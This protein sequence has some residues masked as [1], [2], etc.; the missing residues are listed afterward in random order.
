MGT[1]R[2]DLP[3][4]LSENHDPSSRVVCRETDIA[5]GFRRDRSVTSFSG[6]W[7]TAIDAETLA[8]WTT[9]RSRAQRAV[10]GVLVENSQGPRKSHRPA[11]L[12]ESGT[13]G[14]LTN[15]FLC[16]CCSF[17]WITVTTVSEAEKEFL[18]CR[19]FCVFSP[20]VYVFI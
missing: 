8:N 4:H 3:R 1:F 10:Y 6:N 2:S 13:G 18:N 14:I 11:T 17:L 7:G 5:V 12:T 16:V 15:H 20:F 9:G 19:N